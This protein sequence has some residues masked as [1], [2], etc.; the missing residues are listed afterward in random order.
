MVSGP[1]PRGSI[2]RRQRGG[3]GVQ[4][5][6]TGNGPGWD[7]GIEPHADKPHPPKSRRARTSS[8]KSNKATFAL[9]SS[10]KMTG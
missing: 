1:P 4:A 6:P 10:R 9:T 5:E 7:G 2:P 8:L 3:G